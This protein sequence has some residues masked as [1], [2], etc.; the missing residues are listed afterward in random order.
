MG[1][2]QG[3]AERFDC[4]SFVCPIEMEPW[5]P[6]QLDPERYELTDVRTTF[7]EVRVQDI[8]TVDGSQFDLADFLPVTPHDRE[9]LAAD[10]FGPE[11]I[12]LRLK[13]ARTEMDCRDLYRHVVVNDDL[14]TAIE[15]F[16]DILI[17]AAEGK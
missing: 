16:V 11:V 12:D 17:S 2:L 14:E 15:Q 10:G 5:A 6:W 9:Q 7:D 8:E 1:R 4:S 13:N 3:L